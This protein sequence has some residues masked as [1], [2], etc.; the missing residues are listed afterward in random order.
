MAAVAMPGVSRAYNWFRRFR[1]RSYR[2]LPRPIGLAFEE[3]ETNR[4][5]GRLIAAEA[6][7]EKRRSLEYEHAWELS[8]LQ[9][10]R[11][12]YIADRVYAQARRRYIETPPLTPKD[13]D[14]NWEHGK[15]HDRWILSARAVANLREKISR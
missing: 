6:D 5:Y 1:F 12:I 14:P 11:A 13:G 3:R 4:V 15:Y 9:E 8:Q 7:W 10:Q 2:I